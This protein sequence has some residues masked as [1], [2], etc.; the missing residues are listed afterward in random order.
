M[1]FFICEENLYVNRSVSK[2]VLR[3]L[4][5][6]SCKNILMLEIGKIL[7]ENWGKMGE[8]GFWALHKQHPSFS[9]GKSKSLLLNSQNEN[10]RRL[11]NSI[12]FK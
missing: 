5:P 12:Q 7:G 1:E 2:G 9:C 8:N 6:P 3:V 4:D 10:E 11:F